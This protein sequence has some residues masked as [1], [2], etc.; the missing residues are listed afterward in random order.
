MNQITVDL[1]KYLYDAIRELAERDNVSINQFITLAIAEKVSAMMTEEYL[2]E[3]AKRGSR[4]KFD[5]ALSKVADVE[6][7]EHDKL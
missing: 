6:P 5:A 2:M 3:R 7:D 1:P 4:E